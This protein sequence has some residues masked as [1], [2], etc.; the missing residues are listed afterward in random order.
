MGYN[1]TMKMNYIRFGNGPRTMLILPGLSVRP[2]CPLAESI[3]AAYGIFSK[4]FTVY[5][6]DRRED[7]PEDYSLEQMAEDTVTKIRELGL[8]D[9]YLYGVS[10]GGMIAQIIALKH[11]EL[12][13]KLALASTCSFVE[14]GTVNEWAEA[15]RKHDLDGLL[16]GFVSK[17]Y[18]DAYYEQYRDAVYAAYGDL[19]ED[20]MDHFAVLASAVNGFD[21]RKEA[22]R[23]AVPVFMTG[24]RDDNVIPIASME[25]SVRLLGAESFFFEG[26]SHAVYD[27]AEE[28]KSKVYAFFMK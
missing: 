25:E 16:K 20:E 24:S 26:Y 22:G 21:I 7:V 5:L 1:G 13:R 28:L 2:V 12:I 19:S 15:S 8:K 9:I 14:E 27:E 10:Q 18:G 6:F 3:A 23:I 17:V 4:D 11:P